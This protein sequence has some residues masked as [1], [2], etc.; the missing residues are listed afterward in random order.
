[1]KKHQLILGS[2]VLFSVLFY[3]EEAGV[4]VLFFAIALLLLIFVTFKNRTGIFKILVATSLLSAIAFTWYGDFISF[5]ALFL[6]LVFLQFQNQEVKLKII[7]SIPLMYLNFFTSLGRPFLF[8]Q[9]LPKTKI[10]NDGVKKA[11]AY[12]LIPLVFLGMF[13]IAY[14]FGSDTFSSLFDYELDIDMWDFILIALLGFY[15]SFS[16]W[17]YWIPESFIKINAKLDND[18]SEDSKLNA[19]PSFSFLDLEFERK[20]GEI[21]LVLLNL[22][23]LIFIISYNYEQFFKE[24]TINPVLLSNATH[25][26][27]NAVI[28]SSVMA[29]GLILFYFKKGFNFDSKANFLKLLAKIWV[30]LNA[31]LIIS[32]V[33]KNSEYILHFGM[34][35]KRIG[36]FAF[37]GMTLIG[38]IFTFFKIRNQKTNMYL[39]NQ[40]IWF[41]YGLILICSF[42]N[43][44]NIITTYNISVNKGVD[45]MFLSRLN[46]NDTARRDYLL[47]HKL[48]GQFPEIDR[49]QEIKSYKSRNFLSKVG[50]YEWLSEK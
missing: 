47:V 41:L 39:F 10:G 21:S 2:T 11:I 24:V 3:K 42:V 9:W 22:M 29:V 14:S 5:L 18:F 38:L 20:S 16:F 49:E 30:G 25:D 31:V 36:V 4:N 32:S 8:S 45:P 35:Y 6:S 15:V 7:Q 43:W 27:V 34:T 46:Y 12:V 19:Q 23:L 44:G 37:L 13:F 17:N 1:M 33:I 48:D 28:I 50:Y 26:R 40:M